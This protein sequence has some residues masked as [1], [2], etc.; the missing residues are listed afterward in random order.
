MT[1]RLASRPDHREQPVNAAPRNRHRYL[2][3]TAIAAT[4]LG[5]AHHSDHVVRGN[6]VGWPITGEI[7]T[8]TFSFA[9]Y[10]VVFLGLCLHARNRA[11]A[12]F[13]AILT[14]V[15]AAVV[16]VTHLGPW[17][18]E[19]P[20][21][22]ISVYRFP[23]FGWAAFGLLLVFLTALTCTSLYGIYL[24]VRNLPGGRHPAESQDEKEYAATR[25]TA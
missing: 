23:F 1:T 12:G 7:N 2:V 16:G 25:R 15:G 13:W 21:D 3:G 24:Y 8:F 14:G 4:L 20:R 22:I 5:I 18:V 9:F 17:A 10:P 11:G 19:P 6:H